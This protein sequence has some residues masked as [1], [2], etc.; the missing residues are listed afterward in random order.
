MKNFLYT[1]LILILLAG[2]FL[3]G[4]WYNKRE[5]AKVNPSA[6]KSPIG[7]SDVKNTPDTDTNKATPS[8]PPGI[9]KITPERQQ[10]IGV[11]IG[12]VEKRSGL[13]TIR[14]LGRVAVD[15]TRIYRI[16]ATVDGWITKAL[17]NS[18]GTFV[19][20]N[21]PL[22]TFYSPEFLSA[23]QALLFALSSSDRVQTTG[24]E[25]PA[26]KDQITQFNI[27][28]KQYRD[29]L[30]N[31]GMGDL[32]IEEMI[33][34]R[35]FMENVDITSPGDGFIL[36]RNVSDGQR[37]DKG[38]E[39]YR[40]ADLSHV[41]VFTDTYENEAQYL[42]PGQIVK[43]SLPHQKKTFQASVSKTLPQFDPTTR[44][45]KV[46]LEADN[47]DYLLKPEMFV[48]IELPISLPPAITVPADAVLDSGI[49]KTA[50]VHQKNGIFE[51]REV[52]TGWRIGNR[53]EIVK[54]LEPGERIVTSGTF[55][56][57]SE[58][59]LDLAAQG[60][61][62]T[63][64]KDLVCGLEISQRKAEKEGR[65]ITYGGKTYYFDTDECK[66]KFEK[67]PKLYIK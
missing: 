47:P 16:N 29:S 9:V 2:S 32:Q 53:V 20:K 60:M 35:R 64:S 42:R 63:L 48:D 58:S 1:F 15:E 26:Q 23:G 39:L 65:K 11:K 25:N 31:L 17:P 3:S 46:R 50:F 19:K 61:Y 8:L 41:W 22:A 34:T 27:N 18:A 7:T 54:G 24:K 38:T 49:K 67:D 30:R 37:F 6:L 57:D 33:R 10:L 12:T 40:I 62:T 51:P 55:L 59:K 45:L 13:Y 44:T 28:I 21:E 66:E 52:E 14:I 43:V 56:I 5:A 36:V 4:S